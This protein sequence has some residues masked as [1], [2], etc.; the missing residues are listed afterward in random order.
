VF[1]ARRG[2]HGPVWLASFDQNVES[3]A[4]G[5]HRG[6]FTKNQAQKEVERLVR[7][8][9]SIRVDADRL[10]EEETKK[11]FILPL[12]KALN[13]DTEDS[14]EV[15]AEENI[16]KK[17]VDYGFRLDGIPK[18]FLEAKA[19][20]GTL[21]LDHVNQAIN[22]S[23]LKS[24]TWAILTN[25][26]ELKVYN[27][28][29]KSRRPIEK[30]FFELQCEQYLTKFEKLWLLSKDSFLSDELDKVAEDWG[31]KQKKVRVTP[32]TEQLFVDLV[33]WRQNLTKDIASRKSNRQLLKTDENL[34]ESVQRLL[35]RLIF[36]RVAEDRQLEPVTLQ[37]RLR[38]W[39]GTKRGRPFYALLVDLFREFDAN[40]NSRLF[41]RHVSDQIEISDLLLLQTIEQLYESREGFKYDFAAID[42]DV[43]GNIYEEYLGYVLEKRE[44]KATVVPSYA[45]RRRM[46]IY[47]TPTYVVDFIVKNTL[48]Q[49]LRDKPNDGAVKVIDPAC[50]SGSFLLRALS[51][52]IESTKA[53]TFEE[54]LR[55]LKSSI[56]GVDLDPKAVEIAQVNLL[57]RILEKRKILPILD[58]NIKCGNS[59]IDD[60]EIAGDRAFNWKDEFSGEMKSGGFDIVIGN[61]PYVESRDIDDTEWDFY[62]DH[63]ASAYKRFDLS[64]VFLEKGIT[65]LRD[66]G[67]LGVIISNKFT[68]SDYGYGVRHFILGNCCIKQIVDLSNVQVFRDASTYPFILILQKESR[69]E[70]RES[71]L[72]TV[73]K[74]A[75]EQELRE[76][77]GAYQ[78][79]QRSFY[80]T[81]N[82]IF[83]IDMTPTVTAIVKKL[84]NGTVP[85]EKLCRMKDGIHTGNVRD[86]LILDRNI[87]PRC[88][89]LIT[90]ES[91]DRYT[92]KWKGLWVNYDP[93]VIRRKKGEYGSLRDQRIF[94]AKEKLVTALF[95]LRPEVA[96]DDTQLYANNSVKIILPKEDDVNLKCILACLNSKL[97]AFYH[98]TFFAPTHVR[99][100][101]MQ[102]Y[103]QDF[104]SLPIKQP[105]ESQAKR[106]SGLVDQIMRLNNELS[107][108]GEL[109]DRGRRI[110]QEIS[111][112]DGEI[113]KGVCELYGLTQD[114]TAFV[115]S[116][117]S[118]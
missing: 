18:F 11:D 102:F 117:I 6:V 73:L 82:S 101:Y 86:K 97:L 9:E 1:E 36:I 20:R 78:I 71:N 76:R 72:I 24:T 48:E 95:G 50:G 91:I 14:S 65:V 47:Y 17:R 107:E 69:K 30:L 60:E 38:E 27:A 59:L 98:R 100:G 39:K 56:H 74:V 70:K 8:Y 114:E 103:P 89:K 40:Y 29:W 44:K 13:W 33:K 2:A 64:V 12:F 21:T 77:K 41:A 49:F 43:L 80:T 54:K 75:T 28:D 106:L 108:V 63:Y 34:D 31:K 10:T 105:S 4:E 46:G 94:E 99:G 111:D 52:L 58:G 37:S 112:L 79:E 115:E 90:A 116:S 51:S 25:F 104:L 67:L 92:I 3:G 32:V 15:S 61:P 96:Y 93:N 68:A 62:R 23:W 66:G 5:G 118:P 19:L 109:S 7:K 87:N 55:I 81:P 85:L 35:D 45:Q 42:A 57:L 110:Q 84:S 16:S 83:S 22:Y 26:T 53:S 88:K 113:D